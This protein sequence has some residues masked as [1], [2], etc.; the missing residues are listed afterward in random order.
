MGMRLPGPMIMV[1]INVDYRLPVASVVSSL[2]DFALLI[3]PF[4]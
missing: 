4:S 1:V 2:N 3:A